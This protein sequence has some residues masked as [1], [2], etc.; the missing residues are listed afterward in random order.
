M[1]EEK[2]SV[3]QVL[4]DVEAVTDHQSLIQLPS[5]RQ[6]TQPFVNAY[7]VIKALNDEQAR[8]DAIAREIER[9]F[10]E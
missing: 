4:Q 7:G 5:Q 10:I 2:I 1:S 3:Q 8:I 9:C 6:R